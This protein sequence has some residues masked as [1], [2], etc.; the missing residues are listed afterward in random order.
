MKSLGFNARMAQ[1]SQVGC[2]FANVCIL[3][4]IRQIQCELK[5]RCTELA[6]LPLYDES[7]QTLSEAK[8]YINTKSDGK[9]I[10]CE[11]TVQVL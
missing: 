9:S 2:Y 8:E 4:C 7:F 1:P 5:R 10:I 3:K 11:H 6:L